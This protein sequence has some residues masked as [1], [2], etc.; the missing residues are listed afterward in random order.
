MHLHALAPVRSLAF[1]LF[2][3]S[4][5]SA[6]AAEASGVT[7]TEH[8]LPPQEDGTPRGLVLRT[9]QRLN[10]SEW[11]GHLRNDRRFH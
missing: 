9:P 10:L 1:A 3:L 5:P 6:F 4:G 2:L 8:A 11:Q 7:V